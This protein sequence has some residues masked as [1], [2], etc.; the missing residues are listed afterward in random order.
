MRKRKLLFVLFSIFS[1]GYPLVVSLI[2]IL[3]GGIPFWFDPARDL[4]L[5]IGNLQKPS[6]IG[7]PSG[8]PGIFYGPYWIWLLS[9]GVS[10]SKD[11]RFITVFVLTIPYLV[12]FPLLLSKFSAELGKRTI[13]ILWLLFFLSSINYM[14]FLWNPHLGPLLYLFFVYLIFKR[15][16]FFAGFI[17]GL[18][19]NF[20]ISFGVAMIISTVIYIFFDNLTKFLKRS[21]NRKVIFQ[22]SIKSF[23]LFIFG[24]LV[25]FVPFILFEV[26]HGFN[27]TKATTFT[28]VNSVIYNSA[29]V[30]QTGLNKKEI[31]ISFIDVFGRTLLLPQR[32]AYG[33]IVLVLLSLFFVHSMKQL[34]F[35]SREKKLISYLLF[36]S[37]ILL[38]LF[39]SAKNPVWMYHFIGIEIIV[40][41]LIGFVVNKI[42]VLRVM[43]YVW[44]FIL[45]VKNLL[46]LISASPHPLLMDSLAAKKY[47]VDLIY[48]DSSGEPFTV[49]AYS[50]AIYTYDY[51]YL[52]QWVG[53]S[54]GN[55]P[56][57]D[58][59]TSRYVYL[60]IPKT[61][62]FI[63][64]DFI[65]YR[66]PTVKFQTLKEW[67]L[68]DGTMVI[69]RE[70]L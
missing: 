40:L 3:S 42:Q 54:Y 52:L 41:L 35:N 49:F 66:T 8:I 58:I 21:H 50:P 60:I 34:H 30:G 13:F 17:G 55:L 12:L 38:S 53:D 44:V 24:S 57:K 14:I 39:L 48:I 4:L 27:Q 16:M 28:L 31:I 67:R 56:Q 1:I 47:A 22:N 29:V 2:D 6:L 63:K 68:D 5:A 19:V 43:L 33:V 23:T 51:D 62:N 11:P 69:K 18:L 59:S 25:A 20:H 64:E 15:R 65:N 46:G 10:I 7:P 9:L 26:R 45:I 61:T 36:Q 70:T 37:V 32:A